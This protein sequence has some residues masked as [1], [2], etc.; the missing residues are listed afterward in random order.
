MTNRSP[1]NEDPHEH[2]NLAANGSSKQ[3]FLFDEEA[4]VPE[5]V[6]LRSIM[7]II[8]IYIIYTYPK[9]GSVATTMLASEGPLSLLLVEGM[10]HNS[11]WMEVIINYCW[12]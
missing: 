7:C 2:C 3:G 5:L 8:Y 12:Q 10:K 11:S 4:C 1:R 9:M 6:D